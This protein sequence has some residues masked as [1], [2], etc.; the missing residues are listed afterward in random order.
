MD[1]YKETIKA[2]KADAKEKVKLSSLAEKE[3]MGTAT[4]VNG[5][6]TTITSDTTDK[7]I[8]LLHNPVKQKLI[9]QM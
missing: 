9:E 5:I 7:E 6:D 8:K 2:S 3:S 4:M 1:V